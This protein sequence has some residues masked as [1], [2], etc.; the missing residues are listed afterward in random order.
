MD[1]LLAVGFTVRYRGG[2]TLW[3][4]TGNVRSRFI[5]APD[6]AT[7]G[8][9]LTDTLGRHAVIYGVRT[10]IDLVEYAHEFKRTGGLTLR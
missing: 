3:M 2:D 4:R 9:V 6:S 7:V 5:R 1:S 10:N 8:Y